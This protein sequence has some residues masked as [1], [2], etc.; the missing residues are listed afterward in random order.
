[1]VPAADI[2]DNNEAVPTTLASAQPIRLSG[3]EGLSYLKFVLEMAE[4]YDRF[5]FEV[6]KNNYLAFGALSAVGSGFFSIFDQTKSVYMVCIAAM[7]LSIGSAVLAFFAFRYS[8]S[9]FAKA[10]MI[11]KAWLRGQPGNRLLDKYQGKGE[12]AA[13]M[14]DR[15]KPFALSYERYR[16][17]PFTFYPVAN[18]I[19]AVGAGIV[20]IL[21]GTGVLST[22]P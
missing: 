4:K 12:E 5:L 20:M 1:M 22:K 18:L 21:I 2:P 7:T 10:W 15:S 11:E 3:L 14:P 19:P 8:S 6:T 17:W 13:G 16:R 9:L